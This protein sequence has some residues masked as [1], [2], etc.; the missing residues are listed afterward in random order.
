MASPF[1]SERKIQFACGLHAEFGGTM[2]CKEGCHWT[3]HAV[4]RDGTIRGRNV[5]PLVT[6]RSERE[7]PEQI[8]CEPEPFA[9]VAGECASSQ[10]GGFAH[11]GIE[12][13][14]DLVDK[15]I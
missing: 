13:P 11:L 7:E 9:M 1:F 14:P 6:R 5:S 8:R 4:E 15:A 3:F 12:L 2:L 10:Q